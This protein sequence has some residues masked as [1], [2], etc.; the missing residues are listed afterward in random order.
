MVKRNVLYVVSYCLL[1]NFTWP[2]CSLH[3]EPFWSSFSQVQVDSFVLHL[4]TRTSWKIEDKASRWVD[5]EGASL[6]GTLRKSF[7][8]QAPL[9]LLQLLGKMVE[10]A[11]VLGAGHPAATE[12]RALCVAHLLPAV[13]RRAIGMCWSEAWFPPRYRTLKF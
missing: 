9:S 11:D 6:I 2:Y 10:R 3:C 1:F 7:G 4:V 12:T 8:N 5:A 13:L